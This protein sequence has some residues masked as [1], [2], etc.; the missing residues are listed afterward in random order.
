MG[1][2]TLSVLDSSMRYIPGIILCVVGLTVIHWRISY[3][4]EHADDF[5][6]TAKKG[7]R[8]RNIHA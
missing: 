5:K 4:H 2:L 1:L 3:R 8:S 7:Q 6:R